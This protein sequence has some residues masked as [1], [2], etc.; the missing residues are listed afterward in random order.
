MVRHAPLR[1]R[2]CG[3]SSHSRQSNDAKGRYRKQRYDKP[4]NHRLGP[5]DELCCVLS[6][7]EGHAAQVVVNA[8]SLD[9]LSINIRA[10]AR[11]MVLAQ[12]ENGRG[13]GFGAYVDSV[14]FVLSD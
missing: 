9:E 7:G 3:F 4:D 12:N 1:V 13:V 6:S 5:V 11:I 8:Q 14:G 10:P 2:V